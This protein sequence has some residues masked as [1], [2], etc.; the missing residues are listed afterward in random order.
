MDDIQPGTLCLIAYPLR[1]TIGRFYDIH[2][3]KRGLSWM[4][5][6]QVRPAPAQM[7]PDQQET[8]PGPWAIP[9]SKSY[10]WVRPADEWT[11]TL[12][13]YSPTQIAKMLRRKAPRTNKNARTRKK[14]AKASGPRPD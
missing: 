4:R 6:R 8:G 3:D 9:L 11:L 14:P 1:P 12:L 7:S 13:G 10:E 5:F 2:T